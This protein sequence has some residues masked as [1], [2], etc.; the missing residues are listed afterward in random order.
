MNIYDMRYISLYEKFKSSEK[1]THKL[2]G[3]VILIEDRILLVNPRKYRKIDDRWSI[4]KG[5]VVG[6]I[7]QSALKELK[8]ETGIDIHKNYETKIKLNYSKGGNK[9]KLTTYLYRLNKED[10]DRYLKGWDIKKS[11]FDQKEIYEAKFFKLDKAYKK[12]EDKQIKLLDKITSY[13]REH[14]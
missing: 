10:V 3:I 14:H 11:H 4:P 1:E 13:L 12:V 8:E 6:D 7:L 5:H 2:S 9:K